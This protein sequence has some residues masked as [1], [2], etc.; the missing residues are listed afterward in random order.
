[1]KTRGAKKGC[2]EEGMK[3]RG[4][5]KRG[6]K[7]RGVKKALRLHQTQEAVLRLHL[8]PVPERLDYT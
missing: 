3:K 4:V 8:G 7:K 5:K 6:V 1:M 2:E